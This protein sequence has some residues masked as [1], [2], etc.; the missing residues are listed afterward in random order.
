MIPERGGWDTLFDYF[1]SSGLLI[2]NDPLA[3]AQAEEKIENDIDR[4]L[5]KARTE[6]RFFLNKESSY[7]TAAGVADRSQAMRQ[8][9][10]A[11]LALGSEATDRPS[12]RF[13]L[14]R[15]IAVDEAVR[16]ASEE[17]GL[18]CF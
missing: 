3:V 13:D 1:P 15:D 11:G 12:V 9:H 8:I 5:L 10:I 2:L 16:Q 7:L 18:L 17:E 4:F 6:E 14:E